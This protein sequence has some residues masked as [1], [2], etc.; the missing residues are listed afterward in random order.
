[1]AICRF[2]AKAFLRQSALVVSP[3]DPRMNDLDETSLS[4]DMPFFVKCTF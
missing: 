3:R 1:M 4:E 2:G